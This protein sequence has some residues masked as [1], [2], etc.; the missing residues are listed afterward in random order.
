MEEIYQF[1]LQLKTLNDDVFEPLLMSWQMMQFDVPIFAF[2]GGKQMIWI[3][4]VQLIKISTFRHY[5]N[6]HYL[7]REFP[8]WMVTMDLFGLKETRIQYV[9][10]MET[11]QGKRSVIIDFESN[12]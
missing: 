2:H 12:Q 1:L 10:L 11:G 5:L 6:H 9:L 4:S 8:I 3:Y 7:F